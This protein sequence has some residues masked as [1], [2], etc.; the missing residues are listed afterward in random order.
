MN[1]D[2]KTVNFGRDKGGNGETYFIKR[3]QTLLILFII[4]C[5]SFKLA[6]ITRLVEYY[7]RK[8]YRKSRLNVNA[9]GR[10][11]YSIIIII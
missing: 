11:R 5:F 8:R 2:G 10:R 9:T 6:R 7:Y 4:H 1:T 3:I